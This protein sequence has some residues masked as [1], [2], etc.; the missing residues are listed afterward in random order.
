MSAGRKLAA[1]R[2]SLSSRLEVAK[3]D[4]P[5]ADFSEQAK[6][7]LDHVVIAGLEAA[8]ADVAGEVTIDIDTAPPGTSKP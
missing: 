1:S 7:W 4:A 2:R 5:M 8:R 6:A 3:R